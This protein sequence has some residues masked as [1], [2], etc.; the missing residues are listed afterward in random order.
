MIRSGGASKIPATPPPAAVA[1]FTLYCVAW[2]M[3]CQRLRPVWDLVAARGT[4]QHRAGPSS[5]FSQAGWQRQLPPPVEFRTV[6]CVTDADTVCREQR[7]ATCPTLRYQFRIDNDVDD[8]ETT[9]TTDNEKKKK[10]PRGPWMVADYPWKYERM[11]LGASTHDLISF[12]ATT[13]RWMEEEK[14]QQQQKEKPIMLV[15]NNSG[16]TGWLDTM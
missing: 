16:S 15:E 3:H 1:T 12:L 10:N 8:S 4:G 2:S 13:Q 7:I 5:S 14:A 9:A 6:D 11:D